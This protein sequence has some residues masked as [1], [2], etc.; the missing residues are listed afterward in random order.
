MFCL[1][2]ISFVF[3]VYSF[4]SVESKQNKGRGLVDGKL[5]L[6]INYIAKAALLSPPV[7]EMVVHLAFA[8]YVFDNVSYFVLSFFP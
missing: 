3:V 7:W 8:G 5:A 1:C 2:F 6:L 4:L